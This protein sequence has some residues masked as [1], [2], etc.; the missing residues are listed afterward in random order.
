MPDFPGYQPRLI[1]EMTAVGLDNRLRGVYSYFSDFL[2]QFIFYLAAGLAPFEISAFYQLVN[3]AASGIV[4][5]D[6]RANTVNMIN[7]H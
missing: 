4:S 3:Q 2:Q 5:Y 7:R 6:H 1:K